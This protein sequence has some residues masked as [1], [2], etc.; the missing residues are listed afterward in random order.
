MTTPKRERSI[1]FSPEEVEL[2][3]S[4]VVQNKTIVE[5]KKSDAV[6][7]NEKEQCWKTIEEIFNSTS[8]THFRSAKTLK[9]KYE[10]IKRITRQKSALICAES[11]R[12]V[13]GSSTAVPLTPIEEKVKN[14]ILLPVD[15]IESE[16]EFVPEHVGKIISI[17]KTKITYKNLLTISNLYLGVRFIIS[18]TENVRA[19]RL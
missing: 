3:I 9:A 15:G 1:N 19:K 6:T 8:G 4:L 12:T 13:G 17:M 11:Y 10:G 7:W 16:F 18:K 14:M 5:N 2:L